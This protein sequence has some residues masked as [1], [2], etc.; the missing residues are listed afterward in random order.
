[1]ADTKSGS[2]TSATDQVAAA[3]DISLE[4]VLQMR[5][6]QKRQENLTTKIS[7]LGAAV[8]AEK[9]KEAAK[10]ILNLSNEMNKFSEYLKRMSEDLSTI[11]RTSEREYRDL[12]EESGKLSEDYLKKFDDAFKKINSD[13]QELTRTAAN[14]GTE[15]FKNALENIKTIS[16]GSF[17]E[18]KKNSS[19]ASKEIEKVL[20]KEKESLQK[21]LKEKE[22]LRVEYAIEASRGVDRKRELEE[23][24]ASIARAK[25]EFENN[26]KNIQ[27]QVKGIISAK[28]GVA[29]EE[30]KITLKKKELEYAIPLIHY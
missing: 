8:T 9:S 13:F 18:I 4:S 11:L 19:L 28:E 2:T 20:D 16:G 15:T 25:E 3:N 22:E 23:T 5:E 29:L 12:V 27:E 30:L 7:E 21:S 14:S 10:E 26:K 6:I 24:D 17:E 1:M